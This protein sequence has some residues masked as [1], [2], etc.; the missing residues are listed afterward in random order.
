MWGEMRRQN[1]LENAALANDRYAEVS[2][3][4]QVKSGYMR[5][6]QR[7]QAR[8]EVA[9]QEAVST[10][11]SGAAGEGGQHSNHE[12]GRQFVEEK[13]QTLMS[14]AE[15]LLRRCTTH[16]ATS[17]ASA[18]PRKA[19]ASRLPGPPKRKPAATKSGDASGS[20]IQN[21]R[22]QPTDGDTG[23]NVISKDKLPNPAM[24]G[25]GSSIQAL[26]DE[27]TSFCSCLIS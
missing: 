23:E 6:I 25:F 1:E 8:S 19:P 16:G 21:S 10:A 3:I 13:L 17:S 12:A 7:L 18:S 20:A 22:G 9:K 5:S 15:N 26:A 4:N 24:T 14:Q 27:E 11:A 2:G